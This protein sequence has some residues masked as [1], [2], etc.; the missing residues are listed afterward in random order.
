MDP[1]K[2]QRRAARA[3]LAPPRSPLA[4]LTALAVALIISAP[5]AEAQDARKLAR[6]FTPEMVGSEVPYFE[7]ISGPART[8]SPGVGGLTHRDYKVDGCDVTVHARGTTVSALGL[9][10]TRICTFDPTKFFSQPVPSANQ[11]T[12][13]QFA[14]IAGAN[15][16]SADC[17][18]GCG[19]A[20][21]PSVYLHWEGPR[22]LGFMQF[23]LQAE[24]VNGPALDAS[25]RWQEAMESRE[26]D[27]YVLNT[28]FNC[29]GKYNTTAAR[30][31]HDVKLTH[32][33]VGTGLEPEGCDKKP[34]QT[35]AAASTR[36][37]APPVPPLPSPASA[38][39][40]S[41]RLGPSF[42][43]ASPTATREPL[44]QLI[45]MDTGLARIDLAFSQSFQALRQQV[46]DEG[47]RDLRRE[48]V[49]FSNGVI[50]RCSIPRSGDATANLLERVRGCLDAAYNDRRLLWLNRLGGGRPPRS[51]A[52]TRAPCCPSTFTSAAW[53]LA[54]YSRY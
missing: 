2:S 5:H 34:P 1:S 40:Q 4:A 46:G 27:E 47:L 24:L 16:F 31:F 29:D 52:A 11:L 12:F 28:T 36:T 25:N 14:R 44:P 41:S 18:S 21:D 30:F 50:D 23:R 20:F 8:V 3:M 53:P 35:A 32:V 6:L 13:G 9:R 39:P 19:N 7:T 33:F 17:L 37:T 54:R 42:D 38:A 51:G 22:A 45:C 26:G 49:E 48:A 10:L 43:C 15:R